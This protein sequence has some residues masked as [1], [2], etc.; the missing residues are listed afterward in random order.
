MHGG[1]WLLAAG[2]AAIVNHR[3]AGSDYLKGNDWLH[4]VPRVARMNEVKSGSGL[5]ASTLVP[6]FAA[7]I[8][9]TCFDR[10]AAAMRQELEEAFAVLTTLDAFTKLARG[11]S[12]TL[13]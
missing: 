13:N 7:L 5:R 1:H 3:I 6:D 2:M 4:V 10:E 9:A 8:P 11:G 12:D